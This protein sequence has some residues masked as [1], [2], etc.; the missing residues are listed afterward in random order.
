[1]ICSSFCCSWLIS[2]AWLLDWMSVSVIVLFCMVVLLV[3]LLALVLLSL[4]CSM[5][6]I[7]SISRLL[8]VSLSI[9]LVLGSLL[10][11]II[12]VWSQQ[13]KKIYFLS[14]DLK[15]YVKKF[16]LWIFLLILSDSFDLRVGKQNSRGSKWSLTRWWRQHGWAAKAILIRKVGAY[17]WLV[18]IRFQWRTR[19]RILCHI[20]LIIYVGRRTGQLAR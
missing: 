4:V 1:M 9:I 11:S 3:A 15:N 12:W 14:D 5:Y 8:L 17:K 2:F 13:E 18:L 20:C 16:T 6:F 19:Q 7:L 10:I